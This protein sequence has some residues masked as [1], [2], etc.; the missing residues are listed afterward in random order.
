MCQVVGCR[1]LIAV[2]VPSGWLQNADYGLAAEWFEKA[3]SE[4]GDRIYS[5]VQLYKDLSTA[6]K[7]A[8]TTATAQKSFVIHACA[9][10]LSVN[11]RHQPRDL[12]V[13]GE[14]GESGRV[15]RQSA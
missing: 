14:S 7:N 12:H 4:G 8:S 6:Y 13:D 11:Y 5:Y 15:R 10:Y 9:N 3:L 2:Y 1:M